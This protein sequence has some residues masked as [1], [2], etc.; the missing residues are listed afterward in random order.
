MPHGGPLPDYNKILS[1]TYRNLVHF[2]A[3]YCV[4]D[5]RIP[6]FLGDDPAT[7]DQL[8][9]SLASIATRLSA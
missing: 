6:D 8:A 5:L 4:A 9:V 3:V 1:L 7:L 2:T